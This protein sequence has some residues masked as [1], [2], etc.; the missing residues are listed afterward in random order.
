MLIRK[1]QQALRLPKSGR[2]FSENLF[3]KHGFSV[4]ELRFDGFRHFVGANNACDAFDLL[5]IPR[6]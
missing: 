3:F 5:A 2:L 4:S 6:D 1:S